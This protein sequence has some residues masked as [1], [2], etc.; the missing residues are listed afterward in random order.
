MYSAGYFIPKEVCKASNISAYVATLLREDDT[1]IKPN[2]GSTGE[3]VPKGTYAWAG[4]NP[5]PS[6][7]SIAE[8]LYDQLVAYEAEIKADKEPNRK[9]DPLLL[10]EDHAEE[11]I[12]AAQRWGVTNVKTFVREY[13]AKNFKI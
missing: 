4:E 9:E 3:P 8:N 5:L 11:L 2:K 7:E 1:I 6:L 12:T 10:T 13:S